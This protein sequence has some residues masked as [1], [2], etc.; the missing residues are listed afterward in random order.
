MK[1]EPVDPLSLQKIGR[2]SEDVGQVRDYSIGLVK[3]LG[4]IFNAAKS[5]W[6]VTFTAPDDTSFELSGPIGL[7]RARLTFG[8]EDAGV[9]GRFVIQKQIHDEY[10]RKLWANIW[11]I[12]VSK[13]GDV[14]AGDT[15]PVL[16][17]A[18]QSFREDNFVPKRQLA[19]SIIWMAMQAD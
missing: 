3:G 8:V 10:D 9:F 5:R 2:L 17:N 16:Y 15:G 1:F 7:V 14:R 6:E 11:A 19:E 4:E 13:D 12:R 18:W